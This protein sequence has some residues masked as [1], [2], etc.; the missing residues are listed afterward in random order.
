MLFMNRFPEFEAMFRAV[1]VSMILLSSEESTFFNVWLCIMYVCVYYARTVRGYLAQY[2]N[3]VC[4]RII[5][6]VDRMVT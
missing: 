1:K 2:E 3:S 6:L 5:L 4:Q